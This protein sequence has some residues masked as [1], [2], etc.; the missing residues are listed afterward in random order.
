[1]PESD[2][3]QELAAALIA[4]RAAYER[5]REVVP[6]LLLPAHERAPLTRSH[7]AAQREYEEAHERLRRARDA[8][9]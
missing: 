7:R 9:A 6:D 3:D 8:L 2:A 4:E 5:L 1:M